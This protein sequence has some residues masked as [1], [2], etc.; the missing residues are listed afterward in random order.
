MKKIAIRDPERPQQRL[1]YLVLMRLAD[2]EIEIEHITADN[3]ISR[4]AA[5]FRAVREDLESSQQL[6]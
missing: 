4:V 3:G 1:S 5:T 2:D 6:V